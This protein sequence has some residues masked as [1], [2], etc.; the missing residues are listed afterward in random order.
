MMNGKVY[1]NIKTR[2]IVFEEDATDYAFERLGIKKINPMGNNGEYTL[3]Q[4]EFMKEFI[5]WYYS[6]EWVEDIIEKDEGN[7]FELI[8]E[9][10]KYDDKLFN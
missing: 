5:D 1:R 8:N 10:C 9:E 4:I 3:E 6:G 2:E 7:I